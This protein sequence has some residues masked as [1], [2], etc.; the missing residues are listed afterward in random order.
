MLLPRLRPFPAVTA[1][2]VTSLT[3]FP[4]PRGWGSAFLW[5]SE[6]TWEA[7]GLCLPLPWRGIPLLPRGSYRVLSALPSLLLTKPQPL[8]SREQLSWVTCP[9]LDGRFSHLLPASQQERTARPVGHSTRLVGCLCLS[10]REGSD[11]SCTSFWGFYFL[12]KDSQRHD[13]ALIQTRLRR[14]CEHRW[15]LLWLGCRRFL[16]VEDCGTRLLRLPLSYSFYSRVQPDEFG[17]AQV[18][19]SR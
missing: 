11:W 19:D 8:S 9:G 14:C 1:G 2:P 12:K 6:P 16:C 17:R 13:E 15:G 3:S 5:N 18:S 10:L 7:V 4:R